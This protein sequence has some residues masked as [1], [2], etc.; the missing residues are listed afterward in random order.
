[1]P[2]LSTTPL[3]LKVAEIPFGAMVT[4]EHS[5]YTCDQHTASSSCQKVPKYFQDSQWKFTTQK[6]FCEFCIPSESNWHPLWP[7]NG[8]VEFSS[9]Q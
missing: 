3:E 5:R 8:W 4:S 6:F 1:M 2:T 7:D 9:I